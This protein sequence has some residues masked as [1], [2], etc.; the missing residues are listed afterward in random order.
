MYNSK[1]ICKYNVA[2]KTGRVSKI[3]KLKLGKTVLNYTRQ[4]LTSSA[5]VYYKEKKSG[6]LDVGGVVVIISMQK[7]SGVVYLVRQTSCHN[8]QVLNSTFSYRKKIF[9]FR[10]YLM[11]TNEL[12]YPPE[13]KVL[14]IER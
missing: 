5:C 14:S 13:L 9:H 12:F 3:A 6:Y 11:I 7:C 10:V 2:Y 4:S 8:P 1:G